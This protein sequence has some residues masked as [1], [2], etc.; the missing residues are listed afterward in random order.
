MRSP[1][2]KLLIIFALLSGLVARTVYASEAD[3][4][5]AGGNNNGYAWSNKAGWVN[6]VPTNGNMRI[7]DNGITGN[8]WNN[9]YGWINMSPTNGGVHAT[10]DGALSGYAWGSSLGWINFSGVSI[11][12]SGKFVGQATGTLIGTLN[13]GC[14]NCNVTTDFR[15]QNFRTVVLPPSS[16][17]GGGHALPGSINANPSSPTVSSPG[18][19][20][21]GNIAQTSSGGAPTLSVEENPA[22][23]QASP[24]GIAVA[25]SA[26]PAKSIPAQLFD[27]RLLIDRTA[28]LHIADLVARVTFGSFGRVPTPVAMTF[29]IINSSNES[30]EVSQD[31]TTVQT[32][33]VF[34]KR[35]LNVAQLAPGSY[36]L[37]LHTKYNSNVEDDFTAAFTIT[38]PT[39]SSR[40]IAWLIG[41]LA[42]SIC[43][44]LFL[45]W[46][47]RRKYKNE[48]EAMHFPHL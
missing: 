43:S 9:N 30:I 24:G 37:K 15:P 48:Q 39:A 38:S 31:T 22:S 4:A 8:A 11:N 3:G 45:L 12:S 40:W 46:W 47:R 36:T 21:G 7:T 23:F 27:I 29:S 14:A 6:F 28:I 5:I 32:E 26:T 2:I 10:P 16:G 17:G 34:V 33:A 20:A 41:G 42:L 18:N 25:Q 35:F 13:F 1:P 44:L 19:N